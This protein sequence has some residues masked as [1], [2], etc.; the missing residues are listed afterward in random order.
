MF[1]ICLQF[2]HTQFTSDPYNVLK[3]KGKGYLKSTKGA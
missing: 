2:V 1:T 3:D